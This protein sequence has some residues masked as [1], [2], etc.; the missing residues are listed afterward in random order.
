MTMENE[1][2][3]RPKRKID[4]PTYRKR[5]RA[6]IILDPIRYEELKATQRRCKKR[7]YLRMKAEDPKRLRKLNLRRSRRRRCRELAARGLGELQALYKRW[8]CE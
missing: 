2:N 1:N 4:W 5:W 8:D 3:V 6:R 7:I